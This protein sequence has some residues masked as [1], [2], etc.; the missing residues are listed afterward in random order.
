M[1]DNALIKLVRDTIIA[2]EGT[3]G[4]EG[5]P[6]KQA[7]QPTQ[8]GVNKEPTAYFHKIHDR[9]RGFPQRTDVWVPDE[10]EEGGSMVHTEAVWYETT[11]QISTLSIQDPSDTEQYT[12]SDILNL[13]AYI[14]QSE[15]TVQQLQAQGVGI[16]RI[17]EVDNP[18]FMDDKQRFEAQPSLDFTL[19][20]KQI[21]TSISPV[22]LSTEFNILV[23]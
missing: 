19:T 15:T 20:H 21:V 18:Y 5:T 10:S 8:Q 9:R 6:I 14:L 17:G 13:I 11:F 16:L 2:Q 12:A 3:A 4:I 22:I 23:V 1:L 7:F